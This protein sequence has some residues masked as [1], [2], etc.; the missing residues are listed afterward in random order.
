MSALIPI[1]ILLVTLLT[2]QWELE[3]KT[4]SA[5]QYGRGITLFTVVLLVWTLLFSKE[6]NRLLSKNIVDPINDLVVVLRHVQNGHFDKRAQVVSND[7]IGYAGDVVNE[8]TLGLQERESMQQSLNLAR[9]IQ[10]N[11]L[12]KCNP[13]L[14]GID[15]AGQSVYCDETG[16]DFYD[17]LLPEKNLGNKIRI[18]LGDVSGHGISSAIL[19]ATA[20]AFFR[21]RSTMPGDLGNVVSDVNQ[22]LCHDVEDSGNF[23]TLFCMEMDTSVQTI[24]WSRAGHDPVLLYDIKENKFSELQGDGIA[25]GLDDGWEY[26]E[27]KV[28]D[29]LKD[30]IA[31]LYTDGIWEAK[32]ASG[33]QFGKIRLK[34]V[35]MNNCHLTAQQILDSVFKSFNSFLQSVKYQDDATLIIVK[36]H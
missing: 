17:F 26:K 24:K 3:L 10:Q 21:Q 7:E 34:E 32:D 13:D 35:I 25:L 4:V 28:N 23:M 27:Y 31:I 5:V 20:R 1:T 19:M 18:V 22:L 6:L 29:E 36:F 11:L 16:G 2:L 9:E 14:P 15:I 30:K 8:M 12:P 33:K